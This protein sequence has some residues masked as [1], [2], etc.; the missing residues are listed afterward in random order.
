MAAKRS[1]KPKNKNRHHAEGARGLPGYATNTFRWEDVLIAMPPA[2]KP[3]AT[4]NIPHPL[5][6]DRLEEK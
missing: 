6:E 4:D 2:R 5:G 3:G 1:V